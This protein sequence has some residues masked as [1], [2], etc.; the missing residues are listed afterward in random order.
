MTDGVTD[1]LSAITFGCV[2]VLL[3]PALIVG[4]MAFY[5]VVVVPVAIWQKAVSV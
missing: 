2:V 5:C 4:H 3:I 1:W